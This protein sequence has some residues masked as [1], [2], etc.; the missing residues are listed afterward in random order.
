MTSQEFIEYLAALAPAGETALIVRQT[1]RLVNGEM[2]F[3]ANGAIKASWPAY[4]PTRRIKESEA[5][6]GNTASFIVDRFIDGKPSAGAANCEYVLVMM[7]DDVGTKSKTPPLA[8]TWIMETS[9]GN[10]QWGYVF[11]D[12]PTKLEFAGAINAIAAAGYTDAGACNPVRNFRLPGSV[13][14][15][16]G[17]DSFASR[18]VEF[19]PGREYTLAEVCAGLG[20]TPEVVESLGPRP[21]RLSDDGADDVATWLSEQGLVLSRPNTE[22]WMGVVC[23]N[24]E[25]HTDGNPEGRYLPSGRAYCCLHSH[26]IDLD[27]AWFLEWVAERGGPKHTPGLRDELLQQAMLQTIGRL[28]PTPELAGAVAEVMAEV[29]R[30]E[31]AR[32]DKA[33]WWHR[34]AYVVSDDAYFDMRERRQ[35]TRTNFNALF[36]HVSCRSI[37]GKNPKIE[38]SICFDEHR[39]TKGGRVLDGIAYSAGD[40]VLVAR[41][42]GV[43]GNK[44]RDGR[45]AVT[46]GASDA[47]VRPWLEHA[48]RMI[49]DP[50]EREHVLNIM[51]FKVQHPSIKI[52]HGVLH[53][54]R[55]GSGKDSL[56]APFLWAV[57][58]EGKTNVATV[59]NEEINSQWG[60]AFESEVLV[61]NELRQP[62]ASD[63]RALENRLKPLLAAP[64]ELISIQRKG[65]HPYDAANRLLVL[66]FSNERAAI[67]LPSDD[68]RWFVLWSEAEIMPPDA[69]ARLW[70]WYAGGGLASVA[71]WLRARDVSTFQP[72]AAPPMTEAKA[73]MLQAGLSGSEAWL[74]EQMT[75]RVGLF[76]RGVVGGPWQGFLEGLQ[77]RAPAHI[78][79]VVPALLHAFREAGWEDMGRVYSVEHPTKKHVFRAPDWTGSK[80]EARR[81]VDLPEPSAADIIARVKG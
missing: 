15:K 18:L 28:T 24:A 41:A 45:P 32:T 42:G 81:L 25:A 72:G 79:L 44:W 61:L 56:W 51:A 30:A 34:F 9:A 57:G 78:K 65:L 13:N 58:G 62:E 3:H 43:Y 12:Q 52:N 19:T 69:A 31:A 35:F 67:S 70:A 29:D 36:R 75:H 40:D 27:S 71:A 23:P 63:R 16:P 77:A 38:A 53:A 48:E 21:V 76:A 37:H 49:P 68:R 7:L 22:G 5:W 74:V 59:R 60:Y 2:Q 10:Y 50:A 73:I 20:V 55:P 17:K 11:S 46:G 1:P 39:Q 26:C 80:S 14:F 47:A 33:D 54:G 6:F 64:P 66:A 8:P 4:L